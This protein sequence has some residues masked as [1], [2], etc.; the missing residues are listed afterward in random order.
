MRIGYDATSLCRRTTGIESYALHLIKALLE[1]DQENRYTLFFRRGIHPELEPY[2]DR[3]EMVIGPSS[4]IACEQ[5]WLPFV[6]RRLSLDLVHYPAFPPGLLTRGPFVMTVYDGTLWRNPGWLSWKARI[7]MAPL[8]RR[9]ARR[10]GKV[11]TISNFSRGEILRFTNAAPENVVNAGIAIAAAFRPEADPDRCRGV[12]SRYGLPSAYILSVGSLEPRKNLGA[13]LEA[14]ARL[15]KDTPGWNR[16][17]VLAGRRAWG[18][19]RIEKAIRALGLQSEVVIADSVDSRDL[20]AVYT[21][22]DV[23]VFPSLYEGFGLP[24]L[25]AMACGTPV[26]CSR[27]P[28]LPEAVG[29]AAELVDPEDVSALAKAIRRVATEEALRDKLRRDGLDR[30]RQFDWAEVARRVQGLYNG[31]GKRLK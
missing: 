9:A 16:K 25:E 23:F 29:P 27:A 2:Q 31:L 7:Y 13:L 8:T 28:A 21:M 11:V 30:A 17:L 15:R 5:L 12:R 24:P 4:Q 20:P 1:S 14:F 26:V 3:A 10:A 22:A 18:A 6:R 19:D